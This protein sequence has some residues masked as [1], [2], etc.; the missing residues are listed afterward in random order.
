[1]HDPPEH[2]PAGRPVW[3]IPTFAG[4]YDMPPAQWVVGAIHES[5]L[6]CNPQLNQANQA[7]VI[8]LVKWI[9]QRLE[10]AREKYV[11]LTDALEGTLV[12]PT[13]TRCAV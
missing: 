11:P 10:C 3:P 7:G 9:L 4:T 12:V 13:E 5:L 1:M 8:R 2:L 6:P